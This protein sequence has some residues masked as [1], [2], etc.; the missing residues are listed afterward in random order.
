MKVLVINPIVY[1]SETKNIKR[2]NSIKDTMIYDLCLAFHKKGH[3]VTLVAGEPFKPLK[4]ENY[5]F[6][7]LWWECKWQKLFMPYRL[8]YMPQTR[9]FIKKHREK[10]DLIISS[11]VFSLCSLIAY[12]IAPEKV[13]IW[14][15]LA[16]HNALLKKIPSK[17][18]YSVIARLFMKNAKIVARSIEARNFISRY[19]KNTENQVIDHGV[20][21]DK[22]KSTIE[23]SNYFVVCSQL[24]ER[25][26]INGIIEKFASYLAKY[27]LDYS[28]YIIGDGYLENALKKESSDLNI[29]E[30]I[31]FTGK[32]NHSEMIPIL[33]K[34][35]ALLVNTIKDNSM[36]SIVESIAVGTPIITTD[37]PLN[38]RYIKRYE[39]GIVKNQWNEQDLY[40]IAVNNK[41]YVDNCIMY[42]YSLSTERRVDQFI[43]I[44]LHMED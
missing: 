21:L 25:K 16:K 43:G 7:I 4:N 29:S 22:F 1:T 5:P 38:S 30:K 14:H 15:E 23:K 18:W 33:K 28:L 13:I 3:I 9:G 31:I 27:S 39:L 42:R 20:N 11:E 19:C 10:F 34:A 26:R 35:S 24:I 40:E 8:P 12:R 6:E 2:I 36:I 17:I 41:K 32:L 37:I 44:L